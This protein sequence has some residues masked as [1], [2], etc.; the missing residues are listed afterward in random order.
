MLKQKYYILIFFHLISFY[1]LPFSIFSQDT[2]LLRETLKLDIETTNYY[3]L[4]IWADDLGLVSTG[5][6]ND[7]RKLL[8]SY[9]NIETILDKK[10]LETGRSIIIE[11]ARELNYIENISIDQNYIILQGEV[12]L[13]MIDFDN[14]TTH[15]I[16]ADKI[17]FNQSEKTISALGNIIYEIIRVDNN[18][19]FYGKSLVFEIESWEGIFFEGVSETDRLIV[20]E[21]LSSSENIKFFFSGEH[22]YRTSGD[23]IELNKGSI[24][25]SKIIDPYYRIDADKIWILEPG[26]WAI[27]NA[28]LFV[29]RIPVFYFPFFFLPGDE[30]LFNPAA[31]YK[32]IEGYFINTTSYIFGL[33]E[34][35]SEDTFSFLKSEDTG[36]KEKYREGLFLRTGK[37]DLNREI[38]PYNNGSNLKLYID[39]YSR[40]GFFLGLDGKMS[41][42]SFLKHLDIFTA[43][44]YSKY[45]YKYNTN[46]SGI[47]IGPYQYTSFLKDSSG[48][49]ISIN[50]G[51]Y[52]FGQSLPFRF[53]F[54]INIAISNNWGKLDIDLPVYSDSKFRSH[55]MNREEGLKWTELISN[56]EKPVNTSEGEM[57]YLSW[58][59]NGS[60]N[61]SVEKISPL[62][63]N[64]SIDKL[65][66]KL[67]WLSRISEHPEKQLVLDN[68]Y[69]YDDSFSFYYPSSLILP[70]ISGKISG[71]IFQTQSSVTNKSEG[72]VNNE[73]FGL[74]TDPWII[75]T[76]NTPSKVSADLLDLPDLLGSFPIEIN[77]GKQ[78]FSNTLK[79]SIAPS[80]SINS[81]FSSDIPLTETDIDFTSDFSIFST[82]ATSSL[83]YSFNIYETYLDFSN[84]SIFS[85]NYKEHF[86]PLDQTEVWDSYLTQDKNA[87]NYKMTDKLTIISKPF[88]NT[89]FFK[90]TSFTYNLNTTLYNK[91]WDSLTESF[92]NKYFLWNEESITGHKA[93]LEVKIDDSGNYQIF[94]LDTVLPP[95][96]IELYPEVILHIENFTGS[97]KTEFQYIKAAPTNYWVYK[98]YEGYLQYTFFEKDFFKQTVSIDFEDMDNSFGRTEL[99]LDK[100]ESNINFKEILDFNIDN[101][102][103]KKSSTD[104]QLWFLNFNFLMEDI[105]GYYFQD[106]TGWIS[107]NDSV[108]QPSK[109]SAGINYR[110]NPDPF[111]KNR[112]KVSLDVDSTWTMNLQKYTDTAFTFDTNFSLFIAEFLELS[113]KSKSVNRATYRYFSANSDEI[114][115]PY[116][117]IFS[118]LAKSF[119]FFKEEDRRTS[120]FNLESISLAV[121]HHMSDWELN[122]EYSGE[123]EL[124]TVDNFTEYQWKSQFSLFVTWKPVPEIKKNIDYIENEI[125]FN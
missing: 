38:W 36:L 111:W 65:N 60:L 2:D 41:F 8:F 3:D 56:E 61:P 92:Q 52:I 88:I 96:N 31:G 107:E 77:K 28:T 40:K 116:L 87:T 58:F 109:A 83:D 101:W 72:S 22:I 89:K 30:L 54:D 70:D 32:E 98:P 57:S 29:G 71:I 80:L 55:F 44:S 91:Y 16:N 20:N 69:V 81:I 1:V 33:K 66:V 47:I 110:Y 100:A 18:E 37:N 46:D 75:N 45:L 102:S 106:S 113:F 50:E 125:I 104:I 93:T 49:Y 108:F 23:R 68:N 21:E 7:L 117:N 86:N 12:I 78:I 15:K 25:S 79:Y 13:E 76:K 14:K 105:V 121:I 64:L 51:S 114:G 59:I 62:I 5:S 34:K 115:L 123:P 35:G 39:Y 67:N 43:I 63:S 118:D 82:Q 84:I 19:Y 42:D 97:I 119:N 48:K 99:Y 11:S 73:N 85:M 120:N 26:E 124:V 6:I 9:Y 4:V 95:Q 74:L 112:L 27:K 10:E 94:K 24:T 103:L 53:A 90:D 122:I 17:V